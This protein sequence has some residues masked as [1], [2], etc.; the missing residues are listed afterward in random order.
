VQFGPALSVGIES[1]GEY[2]D[3]W[4]FMQLD[5]DAA[6]AAIN[7]ALPRGLTVSAFRKIA[8]DAPGLSESVRAAIYLARLPGGLAPSAALDTFAAREAH[9]AAREKNG[10]TSTFPLRDWLLEV[11][12]ADAVSFRMT[13]A[14]GGE[15]ASIRPD[16]VLTIMYGDAAGEIRLVRED[17]A[18][19]WGGRLVN[20]M[21][22]DSAMVPVV[23]R[24]AG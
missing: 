20:P 24:A 2:L 12:E 15:G 5:A 21:L 14:V 7:D 1:Y 22:A 11:V 23:E 9:S 19:L 3:L 16:E 17:L 13:L 18:V 6:L 4:S 8:G 10:K